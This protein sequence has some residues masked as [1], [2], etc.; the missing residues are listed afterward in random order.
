MF[1]LDE[2]KRRLRVLRESFDLTQH[3][4]A[5]AAGIDY[6][7]YQYIES[8]RKKQIWLETVSR[9]AAVYRIE[10]WQ[11]FHPNFLAYAKCPRVGRKPGG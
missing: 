10:L 4:V 3:D 5:M 6:K 11:F 9:L 1:Q 7:F 8:P 2:S